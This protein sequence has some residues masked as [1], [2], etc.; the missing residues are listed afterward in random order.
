MKGKYTCKPYFDSTLL[1]FL[2]KELEDLP[3]KKIQAVKREDEHTTSLCF[4]DSMLVLSTHPVLYRVHLAPGNPPKN[5]KKHP[6]EEH[7]KFLKITNVQQLGLDRIFVIG[8][9][10]S[11]IHPS[12][13]LVSELIGPSSNLFLIDRASTIIASHRRPRSRKKDDL[14]KQGNKPL[15]ALLRSSAEGELTDIATSKDPAEAIHHEFKRLPP[16]LSVLMESMDKK[17]LFAALNTLLDEP[18]PHIHYEGSEPCFISPIALSPASI[19][20]NSFSEALGELYHHFMQANMKDR[21]KHKLIKELK[22]CSKIRKKVA[23][24]RQKA[25]LSD[26]FKKKG[27]L[28][29]LHISDIKRGMKTFTVADPYE[30]HTTVTIP[31]D[32]AKSAA[33]NAADYFRRARKAEKSKTTIARRTSE[34]ESEIERLT[35]LLDSVEELPEE[36]LQY[37]LE[38]PGATGPGKESQPPKPF[39][40]FKTSSGKTILVGR[41]REENEHLTFHTAKPDDL[42]FHVREAPGSHTILINDSNI[43]KVDIEEAA[44]VAAHFSKAKHASIVPV[45]YTKRRYVRR[46]KKLGPGKVLLSRE[47][48]L[49]VEPTLPPSEGNKQRQQ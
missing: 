30:E 13:Y 6:F 3:G 14:Y 43:T 18:Q 2:L 19:L 9:S 12:L 41:N 4:K 20:K 8:F 39:R 17:Q 36:R 33:R 1:F 10:K 16:W 38:P 32:P 40:R 25:L 45:S 42:F 44:Q 48:T 31:L 5:M 34:I 24:D 37:M 11:G 7:I 15:D 22:K 49:F 47:K 23:H 21:V 35:A 46:S 28:I 26:E 27:E 29:L